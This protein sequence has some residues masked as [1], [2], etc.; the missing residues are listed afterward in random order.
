MIALALLLAF[1]ITPELRRH[2]DA[3]LKA[4]AAGDLDT[5]AREFQRVVE[6]APTLA[7]AHVNLGAVLVDKKDYAAAV[8]PLRK[9]LELNPDLPG[10]HGMLG[11]SL[12]A[13]G[14][15]AEALPHLEKGQAHDLLGIAL[16]ESSGRIRDA[17]DR[18]EAAL[19]KRPDDP[20]LLYYLGQAHARLSRQ[21]FEKLR[22]SQPASA[23]TQQMLGEARAAA[24]DREAAEK[25]FRAALAARSGLPAVHFAL[26]ELYREAG[27]YEKAAAE[28]GEE[29][30]RAPGCAV[31]A[32]K[33]GVVLAQRGLT[34]D[35]IA[36]LRRANLLQPDM[37][38]T[39][40]ELGKALN[41]AGDPA[42][43]EPILRKLLTLESETLLA[44]SAHFQL[45]QAYRKLGR[46]EDAG[47]EM[48]AFQALRARRPPSR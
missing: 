28:Y 20:D 31:C 8:P 15:A 25:H 33:H 40:L 22:Q 14:Y 18:L 30:R 48:Q 17:V 2:V 34:K 42:S 46:T 6:L 12:L 3:G 38:E 29:T 43:A 11:T 4:K 45:A 13:L 37:P 7:A 5:A 44:E 10:A 47:R 26:G 24:G 39:L 1:Q 41:A 21:L 9:A 19:L 16:L 36:E 32:Y 23:R 35:A 27:D